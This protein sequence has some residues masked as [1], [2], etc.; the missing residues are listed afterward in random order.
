M[1]ASA[2][3]LGQLDVLKNAVASD[4][5]LLVDDPVAELDREHLERLMAAIQRRNLQL[6][7]TALASDIAGLSGD[8][9]RFHVEQ[10]K[11]SKVV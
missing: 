4:R 3:L 2:L 6:I 8:F 10:G 7:I 11:V 5:I 1:L 9:A